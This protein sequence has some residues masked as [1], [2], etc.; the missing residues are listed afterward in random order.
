LFLPAAVSAIAIALL[1]WTKLPPFENLSHIADD[2]FLADGTTDSLIAELGRVSALRVISRTSTIQ[3]RNSGKLLPQ[4]GREL[5]ADAVVEG[6]VLRSGDHLRITVQLIQAA[7]DRQFWSES[8]ERKLGDVITLQGE[9]ASAV[10]A[11]LTP[12][13]RNRLARTRPINPEALERYLHGRFFWSKM[14]ADGLNRSIAD[15]EQAIAKDA[16]YA[17]AYAGLAD[18]YAAL[19]YTVGTPA[20]EEY[21]KARAAASKALEIDPNLAEA[22][23]TLATVA[24]Y[25]YDWPDAEKQFKRALELN[26]SYAQAHHDYGFYFLAM[27]RINDGTATNEEARKLDPLSLYFSTDLAWQ[28]YFLRQYDESI[29]QLRQVLEMDRTYVPALSSLGVV[30]QAKG[31]YDEAIAQFRKA[32]DHDP[33]NPM[34]LALMGNAYAQAGKTGK[35]RRILQ[36]LKEMENN[37]PVSSFHFAFIQM[38]LGNMDRAF[39]LFAKACE[40][41]FYFMALLNVAPFFDPIRSDPRFPGLVTKVGLRPR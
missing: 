8:Y 21:R 26:P 37:R 31:M 39:E 15:F 9:I 5:G 22:V 32:L 19:P 23:T 12:E 18:C 7:T 6:S 36:Q 27:G 28:P 41:R 33:E 38:G 29:R 14:T 24:A 30:F 2:D 34:T 17:L 13:E 35:A 16:D 3:Y 1:V 20:R 40:E 10:R 11:R 25:S 4:I